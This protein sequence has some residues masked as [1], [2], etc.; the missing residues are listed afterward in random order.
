MTRSVF[1]VKKNE[2][3]LWDVTSAIE[4]MGYLADMVHAGGFTS[5]PSAAFWVKDHLNKCLDLNC[6]DLFWGYSS[7]HGVSTDLDLEI[8]I[9][10]YTLAGAPILKFVNSSLNPKMNLLQ[11]MQDVCSG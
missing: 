10:G 11:L 1:Y 3:D 2:N 7:I 6:D 8:W 9:E 5:Q 4:G